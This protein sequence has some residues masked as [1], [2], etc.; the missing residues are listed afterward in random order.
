MSKSRGNAIAL[1]ASEDET[2]RLIRGARTDTERRITYQPAARPEVSN[3]VL[4]AALCLDQPPEQV[5]GEVG[6]AAPRR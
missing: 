2:A 4:L 3:L 6:P 1:A 5:A